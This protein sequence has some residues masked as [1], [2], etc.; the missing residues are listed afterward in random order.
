MPLHWDILRGPVTHRLVDW[1][2]YQG[3]KSGGRFEF[4]PPVP[5]REVVA[6]NLAPDVETVPL[7]PFGAAKLRITSFPMARPTRPSAPSP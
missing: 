5:D 3:D 7:V 2:P 1:T 6:G 4:T